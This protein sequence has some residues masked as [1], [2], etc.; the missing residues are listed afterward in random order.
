MEIIKCEYDRNTLPEFFEWLASYLGMSNAKYSDIID[1][2]S[3][4]YFDIRNDK[5]VMFEILQ[6]PSY[7][8]QWMQE[9]KRKIGTVQL[10][11]DNVYSKMPDNEKVKHITNMNSGTLYPN[12][13][14]MISISEQLNVSILMIHRGKYGKFDVGQARGE[15]DDL[16]VSSTLFPAKS[17]VMTR[18]LLIFHK[19]YE[20]Q[21]TVYNLIVE[22]NKQPGAGMIYLKYNDAP[23]NVKMLI[24]AHFLG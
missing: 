3:K 22:K 5:D 2:S 8:Q 13:L 6:D 19:T 20:K 14:H 17:N 16:K 18:P 4:R 10:F 11:W 24:D 1:I 9:I 7:Y 21:M 15:L 12:D 23:A